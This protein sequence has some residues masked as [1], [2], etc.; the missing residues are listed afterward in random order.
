[1]VIKSVMYHKIEK[2]D[3]FYLWSFLCKRLTLYLFENIH[4]MIQ[5]N[6]QG[7]SLL[8]YVM[9]WMQIPYLT[10]SISL[11]DNSTSGKTK[12]CIYTSH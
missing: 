1:M 10:Y 2:L 5:F 4:T 3:C 6:M 9:N 8:L 12:K 7:N 11:P